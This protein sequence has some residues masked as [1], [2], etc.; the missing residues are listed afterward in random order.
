LIDVL[1]GNSDPTGGATHWDGQDLLQK[2]ISHPKFKEFGTVW[3]AGS[4]FD[5][6]SQA[7]SNLYGTRI[8]PSY[9]KD[10]TYANG[11]TDGT[12]GWTSTGNFYVHQQSKNKTY[13]NLRSVGVK[14]ATIFWKATK[15]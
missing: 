10:C 5:A 8:H 12:W 4:D 1:L 15:K 13:Y 14:G 2:G 9:N 3:V 7:Q 11:K 6:Y